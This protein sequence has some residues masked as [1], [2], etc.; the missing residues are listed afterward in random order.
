MA[1]P[2]KVLKF[3]AKGRYSLASEFRE[4]WRFETSVH[5]W[6][7]FRDLDG[8]LIHP[9]KDQYIWIGLSGL[10]GFLGTEDILRYSLNFENTGDLRLV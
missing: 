7:G 3:S 2:K 1:V 9:C 4:Y 5:G 10:V 6:P 8:F